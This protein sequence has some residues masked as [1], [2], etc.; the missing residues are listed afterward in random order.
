[1]K[2]FHSL[3][4]KKNFGWPISKSNC[5][6]TFI[7]KIFQY[8]TF[9]PNFICYHKANFLVTLKVAPF[10]RNPYLKFTTIK[11][12]W[13]IFLSQSKSQLFFSPSIKFRSQIFFTHIQRN[14]SNL[15]AF[16]S[17]SSIDEISHGLSSNNLAPSWPA[18]DGNCLTKNFRYWER[19]QNRNLK[20]LNWIR[21]PININ[22]TI[23]FRQSKRIWT[24]MKL[25]LSTA[26]IAFNF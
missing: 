19:S 18:A 10:S 20:I 17:M 21:E 11:V 14:L 2:Y 9:L 16:W 4:L 5:K 15:H 12:D 3:A 25:K 8:S 23:R 6:A 1:M 13:E 26:K 7:N 22:Y 24:E